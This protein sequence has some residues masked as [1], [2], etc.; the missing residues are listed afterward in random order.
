MEVLETDVLVVGPTC[1]AAASALPGPA[2]VKARDHE[3]PAQADS[4]RAN[5]SPTN[6]TPNPSLSRIEDP[7]AQTAMPA[8]AEG[9]Q[10]F[11]TLSRRTVVIACVGLGAPAS[12]ALRLQDGRAPPDVEHLANT[13]SIR[14]FCKP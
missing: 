9:T 12:I 13:S 4:P 1:R 6:E 11:A 10:I 5:T 7:P 3:Y 8:R 14:S 2:G